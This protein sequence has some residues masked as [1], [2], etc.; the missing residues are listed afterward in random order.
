MKI[1]FIGG[2]NMAAALIG[3]MLDAGFRPADVDVLEPEAAKGTELTRRFGCAAHLQPGE[4]LAAA[5]VIVLAVKPQQLQEAAQAIKPFIAQPLVV[6]IAAGV[7]AASIARWLGTERVV[8][9]MPNTPALIRAGVS[10]VTAM[11][12]VTEEQRAAATRILQAVGDIVW[13]DDEAMLDPVTAISGSGP[14]YVFYF[15]EALQEAARELGLDDAQARTL[16][17]QTFVGAARLAL[18]T[19]EPVAVLR[20][21]VTS[22]GGTTAAAL[23]SLGN[24]R[25]KE[26][27]ARAVKAAS[28]RAGE[29]GDEFDR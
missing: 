2:G 20:E 1:S 26:A 19:D 6:S 12:A 10:G 16:S 27:I 15:I 3:G 4:W 17:I 7:R 13:F 5:D 21:R 11:P 28:V 29:L 24:D 18:G 8:R 23:A 22:K 14:A 9:A 25:V